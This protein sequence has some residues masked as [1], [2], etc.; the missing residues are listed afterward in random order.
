M[1][2]V[3]AQYN[4]ANVCTLH[5]WCSSCFTHIV[6][7]RN[8]HVGVKSTCGR[9]EHWPLAKVPLPHD[10]LVCFRKKKKKKKRLHQLQKQRFKKRK[11]TRPKE[12]Y[13]G[14]DWRCT[15]CGVASLLQLVRDGCFVQR[16]SRLYCRTKDARYTHSVELPSGHEG[17]STARAHRASRVPRRQ[18]L[19]SSCESI[20]VRR[21]N[22]WVTYI[23]FR[24]YIILER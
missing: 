13:S 14:Y 8:P 24:E 22:S 20:N 2:G 16:K 3:A 5:T 1:C 7:V 4:N 23:L 11:R 6:R 9:E 18:N 15:Y 17:C 19:A 10:C 12:R 21:F